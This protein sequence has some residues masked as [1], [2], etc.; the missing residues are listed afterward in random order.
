MKEVRKN[1]IRVTTFTPSTIASDMSKELNLT[2]GDPDRVLQPEDFVEL[3][4]A[5]LRFPR[6]ALIKFAVNWSTNP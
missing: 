5:T 1:N 4:V 3:L 2:D 6:R